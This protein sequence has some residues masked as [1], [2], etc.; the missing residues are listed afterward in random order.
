MIHDVY[1]SLLPA[2]LVKPFRD[3]NLLQQVCLLREVELGKSETNAFE[4]IKELANTKST[5]L[6]D[7]QFA[8]AILRTF[9]VLSYRLQS[10]HFR[11]V[12]AFVMR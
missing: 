8:K 2:D 4:E 12:L 5:P 10:P 11:S 7:K 1:L 9:L 3:E 6:D